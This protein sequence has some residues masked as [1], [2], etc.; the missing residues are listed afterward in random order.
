MKI[1]ILLCDDFAGLLPPFVSH[2]KDLYI[3][4]FNKVTVNAE[5]AVYEVFKG[6][7]PPSL[8]RNELYVITGSNSSA[9]E[10]KEWIKLLMGFIRTANDQKIP[11]VGI[12]FGHQIIA[13]A[14]GGEVEKSPHGWG[15]GIQQSE[16]IHDKALQY[17]PEGKMQLHYNH[18][19]HVKRLPPD[20]VAFASH[21]RCPN[22]GFTIGD[23]IIT[24]QGHPEYTDNY[25]WFHIEHLEPNKPM[26]VKAKALKSIEEGEHQGEQAAKWMVDLV[27][28]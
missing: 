21:E 13:Q 2:I 28:Q 22:A 27:S 24:F 17:F 19:D 5:Y 15:S 20:A 6:E 3:D 12:C 10:D 23:H 14:L 4:M 25:N 18:N 9:Y 1:N 26:E 11:M 7:Y 16:I 8:S